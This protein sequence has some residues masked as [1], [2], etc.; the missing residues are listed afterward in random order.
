MNKIAH[1]LYK[2]NYSQNLM[3]IKSVFFKLSKL[4]ITSFTGSNPNR[5][6]SVLGVYTILTLIP[7]KLFQVGS[8]KFKNKQLFAAILINQTVDF[9][10][11]SYIRPFLCACTISPYQELSKVL[12]NPYSVNH[13]LH[14]T[15]SF[16]MA[17]L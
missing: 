13:R 14:W 17:L 9:M 12:L 7:T 10:K 2:K 3:K 4:L 6:G 11:I 8:M 16:E 1:I 15:I 5:R